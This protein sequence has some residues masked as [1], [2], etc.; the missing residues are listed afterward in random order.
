MQDPTRKLR[1]RIDL[2][3]TINTLSQAV[4]SN[5]IY[6]SFLLVPLFSCVFHFILCA[7]PLFPLYKVP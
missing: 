4:S 7:F 2:I 5:G 3:V 1:E 6:L